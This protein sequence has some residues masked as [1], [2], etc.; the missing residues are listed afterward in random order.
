MKTVYIIEDEEI[1]RNLFDEYFAIA[2]PDM[3]IIGSCGEGEQSVRECLDLKPDLAIVDIRLPEVNGLEILHILKKRCPETKV[4]LFTGTVTS[5]SIRIALQG[6]A[7]AFVEKADGIDQIKKAIEAV[8]KDGHYYSPNVYKQIL[9]FQ[10]D[11]ITK[12]GRL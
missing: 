6:K 1:L 4:I 10:T 2:L 11:D 8:K 12:S 5:D 7:D 3:E 9:A